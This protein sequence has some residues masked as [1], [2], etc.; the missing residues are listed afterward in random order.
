MAKKV[1]SKIINMVSVLLMLTAAFVLLNIL[2]TKQGNVPQVFGHTILRV[3]TGSMEPAI[4]VD[5]LIVVRAVEPGEIKAGDIISFYSADPAL[6]G[7]VN[8]HRVTEISQADGKW[9]Y[10]T[11]GDANNVP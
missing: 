3:L 1:V 10:Q 2:L 5:S 8:T 4:P 7:A 11:Q 9:I 6:G